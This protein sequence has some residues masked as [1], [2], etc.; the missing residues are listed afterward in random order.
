MLS[1]NFFNYTYVISSIDYYNN[2]ILLENRRRTVYL[3]IFSANIL[4]LKNIATLKGHDIF[5]QILE[6]VYSIIKYFWLNKFF[7]ILF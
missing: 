3:D 1:I 7:K 4:I 6:F 5:S 2:N